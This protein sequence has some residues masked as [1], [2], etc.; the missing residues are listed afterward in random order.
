MAK[1]CLLP[2]IARVGQRPFFD[3]EKFI[4]YIKKI[5]KKNIKEEE[6]LAF[7]FIVYDFQDNS[8]AE[9]LDNKNYWTVL[10]TISG[11]FLTIFYIDTRNSYYT[12]R[13]IDLKNSI[14]NNR[15]IL[16]NSP[17]F[18]SK[19]YLKSEFHIKQNIE[20]PFILFFQTD[21]DSI[22]SHFIV[23]L[24]QEKLE[25]AFLELKAHIKNAVDSLKKVD[26]DKYSKNHIELF[27][28]IEAGVKAGNQENFVKTKVLP[29]I[30]FD[31]LVSLT[32]I[33]LGM[34]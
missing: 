5:A 14:T 24:K 21:G 13:Q 7:A 28:L 19:C 10:D 2:I 29:K 22:L 8:I 9:L 34:G 12:N 6:A 11:D 16:E 25:D 15:E 18:K 17:L 1:Y 33:L 3:E 32:K 31:R 23:L 4:S 26:R 27:H 20:T 30:S